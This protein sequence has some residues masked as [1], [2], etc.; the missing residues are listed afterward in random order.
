MSTGSKLTDTQLRLMRAFVI[1]QAATLDWGIEDLHLCP[2]PAIEELKKC[3]KEA[4]K[5]VKML[6]DE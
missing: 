5:L 4:A 1:A 3:L 2:S 6:E